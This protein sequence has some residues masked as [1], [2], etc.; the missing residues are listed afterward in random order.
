MRRVG[1]TRHSLLAGVCMNDPR[2]VKKTFSLAEKVGIFHG[3]GNSLHK[4]FYDWNVVIGGIPGEKSTLCHFGT[5]EHFA[6]RCME[7]SAPGPK[8]PKI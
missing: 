7:F 1:I 3:P 8:L 6:Y 5:F 2:V 4:L